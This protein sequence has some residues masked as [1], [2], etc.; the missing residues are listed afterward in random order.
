MSTAITCL[1]VRRIAGAEP[2]RRD[3]AVAEHCRSCAACTAF[4]RELSALDARLE[5]ALQVEVPEGL[6]AR[7]VLDAS[8]KHARR[9]WQPWLAAAASTL[10]V[11][12][13]GYAAY[14]HQHPQ[15]DDLASAVV[16]HVENKGEADALLP[17]RALISDASLV[18]GA[19]GGAGVAVEGRL[20]G[21]TY[22][23]TCLF[24]G[25]R[26]AHLVFRGVNGPVTV[27][28]LPHIHVERVM[29]VDEDGFHGF[30]E[31]MGRGSIAI[32][33]RGSTP[34]EPMAQELVRKVRWTL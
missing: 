1:D 17:D 29:P 19:L 5:R 22:A 28:L 8:L 31:P 32:V 6:E 13:L 24:R 4:V 14:L 34:M 25:E 11:V 2:T 3:A 12:A 15:G 27:L 33:T 9:A 18:Q 20:D 30:I 23:Q 10:M 26:V 21:V 7:I 16:G